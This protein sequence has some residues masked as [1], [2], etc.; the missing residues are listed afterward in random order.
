MF[1]CRALDVAES[2]EDMNLVSRKLFEFEKPTRLHF[3]LQAP[4]FKHESRNIKTNFHTQTDI[5]PWNAKHPFDINS[6]QLN[7]LGL[8]FVKNY[9]GPLPNTHFCIPHMKQHKILL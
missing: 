8:E 6:L 7:L 4:N 9:D 1:K 2:D 5:S 3:K